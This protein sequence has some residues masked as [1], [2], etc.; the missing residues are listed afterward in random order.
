MESMK[1]TSTIQQIP[2]LSL[3]VAEAARSTG[4]SENY[5]RLLIGRRELPHVRV[6]RAVRLMVDDLERFLEQH[7]EAAR[8]GRQ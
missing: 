4:F 6:G 7:R 2:Q 1:H 8:T 3:T 5:I